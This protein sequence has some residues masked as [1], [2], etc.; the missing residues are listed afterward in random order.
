MK[1]KQ[2]MYVQNHKNG[3]EKNCE[4]D[5]YKDTQMHQNEFSDTT[6]WSLNSGGEN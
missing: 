1:K 2:N 4:E 3:Y 6:E 5:S